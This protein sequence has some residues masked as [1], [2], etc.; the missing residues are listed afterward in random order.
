MKTLT[1]MILIFCF[2][3]S[4]CKAK[5]NEDTS[6]NQTVSKINKQS[7]K[8]N[9]NT[10][11]IKIKSSNRNDITPAAANQAKQLNQPIQSVPAEQLNQPIQSV[12]AEQSGQTVQSEELESWKEEA[13]KNLK[14]VPLKPKQKLTVNNLVN[15]DLAKKNKKQAGNVRKKELVMADKAAK[16]KAAE[17]TKLLDLNEENDFGKVQKIERQEPN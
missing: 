7:I 4:A 1:L 10:D 17:R 3:F 14:P 15:N 11:E 6:S 5:K 9:S 2:F 13:S 8:Q 12:P 16:M